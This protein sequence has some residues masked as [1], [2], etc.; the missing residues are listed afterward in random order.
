MLP[1]GQSQRAAVI[2]EQLRELP[3]HQAL[4]LRGVEIAEGGSR[5]GA[6]L[7]TALR[8]SEGTLAVEAVSFALRRGVG[9]RCGVTALVGDRSA[10]GK[11]GA[12]DQRQRH[13]RQ[14]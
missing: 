2:A 14:A 3:L 11:A 1:R 6:F 8:L 9:A 13:Q 10:G 12:R 7:A 5:G 4:A